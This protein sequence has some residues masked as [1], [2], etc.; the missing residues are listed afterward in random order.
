MQKQKIVKKPIV[1]RLNLTDIPPE[2]IGWK[3]KKKQQDANKKRGIKITDKLYKKK[4]R[5]NTEKKKL[6]R[7][8]EANEKEAHYIVKK[9]V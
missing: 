1:G 2:R 9:I 6:Q 3:K 8:L 7:Q 5:D 4:Y